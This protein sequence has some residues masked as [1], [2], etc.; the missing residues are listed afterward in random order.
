MARAAMTKGGTTDEIRRRQRAAVAILAG[1]T[2]ACG[3]VPTKVTSVAE[4]VASVAEPMLRNSRPARML[5]TYCMERVQPV[6]MLLGFVGLL[7]AAALTFATFQLSVVPVDEPKHSLLLSSDLDVALQV[8]HQASMT[9]VLP[10]DQVCGAAE[11]PTGGNVPELDVFSV[12]NG[13][14]RWVTKF[15]STNVARQRLIPVPAGSG[16]VDTRLQ[17]QLSAYKRIYFVEKLELANFQRSPFSTSAYQVVTTHAPPN[18]VE[19]AF[20]DISCD[21]VANILKHLQLSEKEVVTK[22]E[23]ERNLTATYHSFACIVGVRQAGLPRSTPFHFVPLGT[24][25]SESVRLLLR[26]GVLCDMEAVAKQR[27]YEAEEKERARQDEEERLKREAEEKEKEKERK[28]E[29]ARLKR[30]AEKAEKARQ[31]AAAKKKAEEAVAAKR[32]QLTAEIATLRQ[33]LNRRPSELFTETSKKIFVSTSFPRFQIAAL[34][35]AGT[36]KSTTLRWLSFYAG[37]RKSTRAAFVPAYASGESFTR[38]LVE[39]GMNEDQD[40]ASFAVFDTKGLETMERRNPIQS[41]SSVKEGIAILC[42][43][44]ASPTKELSYE[45]SPDANWWEA[46]WWERLLGFPAPALPDARR[47]IH[48]L[49]FVTSYVGDSDVETLESSRSFIRSLRRD[50]SERGIGLVVGVTHLG[51]DPGLSRAACKREV[52]RNFGLGIGEAVLLQNAREDSDVSHQEP[53]GLHGTIADETA[54]SH[55]YLEPK[56]L[57]E[58]VDRLQE[59]SRPFYEHQYLVRD[60]QQA[61]PGWFASALRL[62]ATYLW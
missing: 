29:E 31:E 17:A 8:F 27:A 12:S 30:E 52:E 42:E 18:R 24:P 55:I 57:T 20:L 38:K 37:L 45:K 21:R 44:R 36:G 16:L 59:A 53:S 54:A 14:N 15:N 48:A 32:Q 3:A 62:I 50:L 34:G 26:P 46:R 58:L 43:G 56:T 40:A 9:C 23:C 5:L 39:R 19:V 2:T 51:C 28:K 41:Y 4:P 49:L 10:G 61:A 1:G 6:G 7:A 60:Q 11:M 33:V 22:E 25:V 13:V 35:L 47:K